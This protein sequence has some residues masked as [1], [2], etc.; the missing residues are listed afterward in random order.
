MLLN[1]LNKYLNLDTLMGRLNAIFLIFITSIYDINLTIFIVIMIII[2]STSFDINKKYIEGLENK[3]M[4]S[5]SNELL[6]NNIKETNKNILLNN[7]NKDVIIGDD[8]GKPIG[9]K[10]DI[11]MKTKG[12]N[13]IIF[14]NAPSTKQFRN[15]HCKSIKGKS[16]KVL[17]NEKGK[18]MTMNEIKKKY[19]INFMNGNEC[20]PC[21]DICNYTITDSTEQLYNE[22]NLRSKQSK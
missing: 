9:S 11:K 8:V 18:E 10:K 2:L 14:S 15:D 21:N 6:D 7:L 16:E 1:T 3:T 5:V 22:E 4:G 19:P 13:D 17:L 20:N 12:S